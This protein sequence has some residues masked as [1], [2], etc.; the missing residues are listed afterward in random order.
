M[1]GWPFPIEKIYI[2]PSKHPS[3]SHKSPFS[4]S[5]KCTS[6]EWP[7]VLLENRSSP[8]GATHIYSLKYIKQCNSTAFCHIPV[9]NQLPLGTLASLNRSISCYCSQCSSFLCEECEGAHRKLKVFSGHQLKEIGNFRY[10]Q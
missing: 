5:R 1:G 6:N 2:N 7:W 9:L 8:D 3:S 10:V 4:F